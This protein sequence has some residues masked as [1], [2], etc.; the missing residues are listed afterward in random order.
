[1]ANQAK[2][3]LYIPTHATDGNELP[4]ISQAAHHWLVYGPQSN[5]QGVFIH[6]G[7]KGSHNNYNGEFRHLVVLTEDHPKN[8]SF[9]KQLAAHAAQAAGHESC[10]LAKE[11][12]QGVQTWTIGNKKART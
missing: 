3:T 10:L 2:Y 11:N 1:M 6:Q 12:K 5:H 8:D 9:I 4:D 7:G